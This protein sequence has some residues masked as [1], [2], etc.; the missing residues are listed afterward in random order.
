[1]KYTYAT[2]LS[3]PRYLH[4]VIVLH[5]SLKKYGKSKYPFICVCSN[6]IPDECL[7]KLRKNGIS[8]HVLTERA[9]NGVSF[10]QQK[11]GWQHWSY[12]FDKLLLWG[13]EEYDKVVFIDS[14]ML[15][16][17]PI[18]DLFERPNMS[19]VAA[20]NFK[21]PDWTRLNSGL[22]VFRPSKTV[23]NELLSLIKPTIE[24][25]ENKESSVGDQDVINNY[26]KD[27][28]QTQ[29]LHISEEYNVFYNLLVDYN[30]TKLPPPRVVHFVGG[31]KPWFHLPLKARLRYIIR[32][33]LHNKDCFWP[34][35]K[36]MRLLY[37]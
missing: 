14:D 18:D 36:Y 33:F 16:L 24:E 8:Y 34:Y 5:A 22:M 37:L 32:L 19:A 12:S 28:P 31:T 29:S 27:W 13:L 21:Y 7:E 17:S 11:E 4:G 1:M 2:L 25:F 9:L 23:M 15:V 10:P 30:K 6:D 3:T 26:K 35:M 20:G